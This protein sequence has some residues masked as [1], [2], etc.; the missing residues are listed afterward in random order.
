MSFEPVMVIRETSHGRPFFFAALIALSLL[1]AGF[2]APAS[3]S[4]HTASIVR[5]HGGDVR[6]LAV[7]EGFAFLGLP[8]AAPPIG[9]LRWKAPEPP[10]KWDGIRDG[11]T[12]S[13]SCPQPPG[14]TAGLMNEDCLYLNVYTPQLGSHNHHGEGLPVL[15]WIH[16]GGFTQGA[17]RDYDPRSWRQ[18][19]S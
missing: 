11:T 8:Y 12:F 7:P 17:G 3:A 13:P 16:G 1:A 15:V 14:F 18:T 5:I 10:A 9:D 6:G 2:A 4:G 19:A